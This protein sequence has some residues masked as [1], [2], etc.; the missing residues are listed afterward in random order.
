M[1][2]RK[3]TDNVYY[4]PPDDIKD[5]P[6]L[7]YIRGEKYALAVDGGFSPAHVEAFYSALSEKGLKEPDYTVLTHWHWDHS[8]GLHA[9]SGKLICEKR[10]NELISEENE[11]LK[12]PA[13]EARLRRNYSY[14]DDEFR[15]VPVPAIRTA[16]IEF[17]DRM[18]IDL[19]G[20]KVVMFHTEAPHTPDSTLIY[21]PGDRVLFL[22]D[23][24]L[25]DFDRSGFVDRAKQAVLKK[26]IEETDCDIVLLG[27]SGAM[28]KAVVL[29]W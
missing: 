3:L 25:G 26:T 7:G 11:R 16:D 18:E 20:V 24:P 9:I 1:L 4:Y 27:H 28:K 29:G 5:R 22:G 8:L 10:T 12:D 15:G 13:Y 14:V 21:V 17:E 19:G 23:A 2:L 6:L